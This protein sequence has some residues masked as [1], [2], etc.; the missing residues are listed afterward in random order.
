MLN[1]VSTGSL[2][3]LALEELVGLASGDTSR[4]PREGGEWGPDIC[5]PHF[6]FAG[7][8]GLA[9]FFKWGSQLLRGDLSP[10]SLFFPVPVAVSSP[11]PLRTRVKVVTYYHLPQVLHHP[12]WFLCVLPISLSMVSFLNNPQIVCFDVAAVSCK[13]PDW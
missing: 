13:D 1:L 3:S 8:G 7:C 10:S 4:R 6:L 5:F 12:L 11:E 9:M 2:G